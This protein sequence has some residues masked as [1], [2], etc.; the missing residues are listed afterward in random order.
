MLDRCDLGNDNPSLPD[1]TDSSAAESWLRV[2]PTSY[3]GIVEIVPASIWSL[4]GT[5]DIQSQP[6]TSKRSAKTRGLQPRPTTLSP[7]GMSS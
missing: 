3:H 7:P 5:L 4:F 2:Q 6:S 1:F